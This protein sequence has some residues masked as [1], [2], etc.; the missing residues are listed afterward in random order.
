MPAGIIRSNP[1]IY[2]KPSLLLLAGHANSRP[3][4]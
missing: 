3:A 4:P 2:K 1:K